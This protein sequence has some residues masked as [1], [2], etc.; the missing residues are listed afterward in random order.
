ML[1]Y[2][3]CARC[4]SVTP[5]KTCQ[6]KRN[7]PGQWTALSCEKCGI[8]AEYKLTTA[9]IVTLLAENEP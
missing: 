1:L 3:Y 5:H 6:A 2:K 7:E 9:E 4:H 8:R